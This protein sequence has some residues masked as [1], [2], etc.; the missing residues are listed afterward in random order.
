MGQ[1]ARER[2]ALPTLLKYA[3]AITISTDVLIDD[4][5]ELPSNMSGQA[6]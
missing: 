2:P 5:L 4:E 1:V 6:K 3:R